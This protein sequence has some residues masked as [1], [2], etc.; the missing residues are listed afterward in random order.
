M[1][2]KKQNILCADE[3]FWFAKK[4]ISTTYNILGILALTSG[5]IFGEVKLLANLKRQTFQHLI[6]KNYTERMYNFY[7]FKESKC[8]MFT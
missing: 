2:L 6:L 8:C 3:F 1:K 7:K 5:A 4:V